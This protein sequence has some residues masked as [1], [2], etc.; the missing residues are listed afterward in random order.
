VKSA[1]PLWSRGLS[2]YR[3]AG[4]PPRTAIWD[5]V[6]LMPATGVHAQS[7]FRHADDP[8]SFALYSVHE[9]PRLALGQSPAGAEE[10]T[11]VVVREFR[12]VPL[13]VSGL[14]LVLFTA[15]PGHAARVIA[16]LAHWVERAVSHY[17]PAYL[18]LARSA[19]EPSLTVLLTGVSQTDALQEGRGSPFSLA[20]VLPEIASM[21]AEPPARYVYCADDAVDA[22]GLPTLGTI[23]PTAI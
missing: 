17:Q 8:T 21:L 20:P 11:L 5:D 6:A 10:H 16:T 4:V 12:R 23:S 3:T 22:D 14:A 9:V 1:R 2:L 13:G 7:R 15:R 18:L 19:D